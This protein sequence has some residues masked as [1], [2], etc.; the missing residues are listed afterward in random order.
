MAPT[1][2]PAPPAGPVPTTELQKGTHGA[3]ENQTKKTQHRRE[4][5]GRLEKRES[6]YESAERQLEHDETEIDLEQSKITVEIEIALQPHGL[7]VPLEI[8]GDQTVR[9]QP[10]QILAAA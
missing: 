5:D 2:A 3:D 9:W 4:I 6:R 10:R 8:V 1:R 7:V